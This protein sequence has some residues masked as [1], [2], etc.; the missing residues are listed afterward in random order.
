[1][2]RFVIG[3]RVL[4][5]PLTGALRV[6]YLKFLALDLAGAVL[7]AAIF[8]FI[9]FIFKETILD[10]MPVFERIR[11]GFIVLVLS[12]IA[13]VV[14]FKLIRRRIRGKPDLNGTI[15]RLR[16]IPGGKNKQI[17]E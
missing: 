14:V 5:A 1:M 17:D 7:W 16:S 8:L 11:Y 4:S 9:G 13:A 3:V 6:G 10:L 2:A 12:T 15:Q